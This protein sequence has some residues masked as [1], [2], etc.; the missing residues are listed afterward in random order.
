[1]SDRAQILKALQEELA[2][3]K[4]P[5]TGVQDRTVHKDSEPNKST[6]SKNI[7]LDAKIKTVGG[8]S[9]GATDGGK[10]HGGGKGM[11][12]PHGD[13]VESGTMKDCGCW[14]GTSEHVKDNGDGGTDAPRRTKMNQ[15]GSGVQPK[16]VGKAKTKTSGSTEKMNKIGGNG[17]ASREVKPD[18]TKNDGVSESRVIELPHDTLV[19][20]NGEVRT[21][22]KGTKI[23]LEMDGMD[24][25][26]TPPMDDIDFVDQEA[27]EYE[28]DE[29]MDMSVIDDSSIEDI[30]VNDPGSLSTILSDIS[31][32]IKQLKDVLLAD[33]EEEFDDDEEIEGMDF[34]DEEEIDDEF[35]TEIDEKDIGGEPW[36]SLNKNKKTISENVDEY[37]SNDF[38]FK[39]ILTDHDNFNVDHRGR[40]IAPAEVEA[41]LLRDELNIVV[42]VGSI[43]DVFGDVK[44]TSA[45]YVARGAT[46]YYYGDMPAEDLGD[47]EG[48]DLTAAEALRDATSEY[49]GG[50]PWES[51]NKN[52]KTISENVDEYFS[53]D[54]KFEAIL[55]NLD[56]F[57]MDNRGGRASRW[58]I[59]PAEVEAHLLR[60]EL[61]IVILI[62]SI[63]DAFGDVK[64]T[65]AKYVAR[66][67][68][69]SK[70]PEGTGYH[71]GDMPD[72]NIVD[73]EF[74][75]GGGDLTAAEALRDAT[76][77]YYQ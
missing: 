24:D 62:G 60:D 65:P 68:I 76:S 50:E 33:K 6:T 16:T 51:L 29:E 72:D 4:A 18:G 41:H 37:F 61:N 56:N 35:E 69:F 21:L 57:Y 5:G 70:S 49:Y 38:K 48:G 15:D 7:K 43:D 20:D 53:N 64:Y 8:E 28:D 22:P 23:V 27:I 10:T 31:D 17:V 19:E 3:Y 75:K 77:E 67:A 36:E 66:G 46:G 40:L 34:D 47:A 12:K 32:D 55:T 25:G 39:A 74:T 59:T 2:M 42:L 71:Y 45:K 44:Y 26:L 13:G 54:F 58:L 30:D 73:Q 14:D 11:D 1:M 9:G 52:K 63:D